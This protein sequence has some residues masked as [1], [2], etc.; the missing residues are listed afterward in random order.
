MKKYDHRAYLY[1]LIPVVL[2]FTFSYFPF[3]KSFASSFFTVGRNGEFTSFV[4]FDNYKS[5]FSNQYFI[6]SVKTTLL[7]AVIFVPLNTI[8]TLLAATLVR[9]ESRFNEIIGSIYFIPLAFSLSLSALLFKQIFSPSNSIIN[10]IFSLD[11]VW[12][13]DRTSA[14]FTIM[15]LCIFLDFA[16]DYI[17]LL[18][19]FRHIER[20]IIEASLID[21]ANEAER[22]FLIELPQIVPTI[23]M[24]AFIAL[25]DVLLISAPIMLL[26]EGGPFRSTESVM[27]YYYVEA[28]RGSNRA[29]E[30][31]ISTIVVLCSAVLLLLYSALQRRRH[32][33]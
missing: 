31:T 15:I 20:N 28:F 25:K 32:H 11:I 2:A 33:A 13:N 12:L 4:A 3:L 16:L 26:T 6:S 8:V 17:L 14:I 18:S 7:L 21:G 29:A 1:I 22:Y 10:R 9:R 19:S 23:L 27:F 5:L 24:T 30:S